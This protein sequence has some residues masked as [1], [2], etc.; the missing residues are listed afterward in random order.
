ML[1][2]S[3]VY[4]L[5]RADFARLSNAARDLS[6][7]EHAGG[8]LAG[9]MVNLT[10]ALLASTDP[11]NRQARDVIQETL[12]DTLSLYI[13]YHLSDASL[14]A[15]QIASAN[16]VSTRLLHQLWAAGGEDLEVWILR[17]RLQGAR[18]DAEASAFPREAADAIARRWGFADPNTFK[19]HYRN[20][21]GSYP[22]D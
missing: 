3:N 14:D 20:E 12:P 1:D 5:V 9:A 2:S 7:N 6:D 22:G 17:Q 11:E 13:R 19:A 10:R 8:P 18:K 16:D 21:Y 4:G 15:E